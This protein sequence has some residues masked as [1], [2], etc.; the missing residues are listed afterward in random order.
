MTKKQITL[1]K[2]LSFYF[3]KKLLSEL[4]DAEKTYITDIFDSYMK[5][6]WGSFRITVERIT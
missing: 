5:G 2:V 6:K 1:G 4:T 3:S